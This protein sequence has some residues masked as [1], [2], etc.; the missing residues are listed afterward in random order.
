L[1]LDAVGGDWRHALYVLGGVLVASAVVWTVLG[2]QRIT[3]DYATRARSQEGS[4]LGSIF[5]YRDLW[6]CCLAFFGAQVAW[7]AFATFWPTLMLDRYGA[8]L[9]WSGGILGINSMA[10]A[11]AGL[12]IGIIASKPGQRRAVLVIVGPL[13]ALTLAAMNLT[14]SIP[15]LTALDLVN[16]LS[17]GFWPLLMA[18]PF[19]LPGIKPREVAVALA[20]IDTSLLAGGAVGPVL[21]GFA[22]EATGDIRVALVI[23]SMFCLTLSLTGLLVR[24]RQR[25]VSTPT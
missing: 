11:A 12:V 10:A 18:L 14:S 23:A 8:S 15:L 4:P 24:V 22:Q 25:G 7:M 9:R 5:R 6:L 13:L 21:A 17:W 3:P 20:L 1:L 16:G 2:R 19:S